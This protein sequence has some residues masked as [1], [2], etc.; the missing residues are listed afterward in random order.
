M[1]EHALSWKAYRTPTRFL[2]NSLTCHSK[3]IVLKTLESLTPLGKTR[4]SEEKK[5]KAISNFQF[6]RNDPCQV[7]CHVLS[8]LMTTEWKKTVNPDE[9]TEPQKAE[10]GSNSDEPRFLRITSQDHLL[11]WKKQCKQRGSAEGGEGREEG[12]WPVTVLDPACFVS[13]HS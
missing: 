10:S 6:S 1:G 8:H 12:D 2:T 4:V 3:K 5:N 11:Q 9:E 7:L 13:S